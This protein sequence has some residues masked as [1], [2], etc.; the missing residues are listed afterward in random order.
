MKIG[1]NPN[2]IKSKN[3][4]TRFFRSI[5]SAAS[6]KQLQH[7]WE[8]N[9]L[10]PSKIDLANVKDDRD[11][12]VG[13]CMTDYVTL[14]RQVISCGELMRCTYRVVSGMLGSSQCADMHTRS[15]VLYD[16]GNDCN[17]V[18]H[19]VEADRRLKT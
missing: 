17:L 18:L 7:T 10:L 16:L 5:K 8:S 11:T 3:D 12:S 19:H 15:S 9:D 14:L 4:K 1:C 2:Y 13:R 6:E